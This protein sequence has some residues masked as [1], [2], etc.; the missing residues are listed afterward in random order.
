MKCL[1]ERNYLFTHR[2]LP[3]TETLSDILWAHPDSVKLFNTF[4]TV[5]VMDST[6]KVNKYR[7]PFLEVV[8]CTSTGKAYAIAFGFLTSEKEDNF[9]RALRVVSNFFQCKDELKVIVTDQD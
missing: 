7:I 4:S 2:V 1:V 3:G 5:L 8:G 6:Y 9:V